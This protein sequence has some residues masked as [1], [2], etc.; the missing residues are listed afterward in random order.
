M[1]EAPEVRVEA[2]KGIVGNADQGGWRQVTII[3]QESWDALMRKVGASL[4]PAARRANLLVSGI[5]LEDTREWNLQVGDARLRIRGETR[6]C[7]QMDQA[8]PGLRDAM[9]AGWGGGVFAEVLTDGAI[10][11]G[12]AVTWIDAADAP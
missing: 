7:E 10:A 4:D 5:D 1:A 9:R 11:V 2:G 12:D 6:P 8:A 3:T